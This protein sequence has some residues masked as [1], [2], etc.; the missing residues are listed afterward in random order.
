ML[1]D[2]HCHTTCSDGT[3]TPQQLLAR[4]ELNDVN[5]LSITDH[6]SV[7]CYEQLK[8]YAGPVH[9]VPGTECSTQ[10][11]STNV[12]ILGLNIDPLHQSMTTLQNQ[13]AQHRI[14][15]AERMDAQLTKLG[16]PG[17]YAGAQAQAN[18]AVVGRP[19][20]AQWLIEQGYCKTNQQAFTRWLGQGKPGYVKQLW[21]NPDEVIE[22]IQ[23]SGGSAVLAH[24]ADYKLTLSKLTR[25]I[26]RFKALG[27]IG[28]EVLNGSQSQAVT[29]KLSSLARKHCL[30]ASMGSD[31]H[32]PHQQWIELGMHQA[33][34][35]GLE[36]V[37]D[38][39]GL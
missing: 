23:A 5:M 3:L 20:F 10:I 24:P 22:A 26:E 21:V 16:M 27:G 31:F 39:F 14:N 37:W 15:R 19:H 28:L 7:S 9:I 34:P 4:A 12:H 2:L 18:N 11:L 1:I 35:A 8:D 36:P 30:L 17:A 6:D 38:S 29:A 13:Q 25:L 32:G 33:L